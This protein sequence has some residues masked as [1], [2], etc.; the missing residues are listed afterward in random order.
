MHDRD[1][2]GFGFTCNSIN[3]IKHFGCLLC[4]ALFLRVSLRAAAS[5]WIQ[6]L[7]GPV[8]AAGFAGARRGEAPLRGEGLRHSRKHPQKT[9]TKLLAASHLST[10]RANTVTP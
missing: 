4:A 8:K 10:G 6:A 7:R 3:H 5:G 1:V 2:L 9:K